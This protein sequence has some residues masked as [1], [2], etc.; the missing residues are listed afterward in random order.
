MICAKAKVGS[1]LGR[2]KQLLIDNGYQEDVLLSCIK[3]KLDNSS[4]DKQFGPEKCKL[5]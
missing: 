5:V 1:E 3:E 2:I 4:S